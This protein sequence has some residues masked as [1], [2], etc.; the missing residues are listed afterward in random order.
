MLKWKYLFVAILPFLILSCKKQNKKEFKEPEISVEENLATPALLK[1]NN[2]VILGNSITHA[3]PNLPLG[4]YGDWGMAASAEEKDYVHVLKKSFQL[5]NPDVVVKAKNVQGFELDFTRYNFDT[6]LKSLRDTHPDLVIL[7]IGENL[8]ANIDMNIF[9]KRYQDLI[10]YFKAD[11]PKVIV[12]GVSTVF[13][14]MADH[15]MIKYPPYVSLET[16]T[17]DPANMALGLFENA[18]VSGHPGDTGMRNIA[19]L[20][21]LKIKTLK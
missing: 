7:R 9:E 20:I 3:G 2:V 16:I 13:R 10:N 1:F 17:Q 6:E 4:W 21:W 8:Q 12:V 14:G 15:V 11:N 18:A 19:S 5:R